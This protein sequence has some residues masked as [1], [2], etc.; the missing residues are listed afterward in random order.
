MLIEITALKGSRLSARHLVCLSSASFSAV[1]GDISYDPSSGPG[2]IEANT[3]SPG[4]P[5]ANSFQ[6]HRCRLHHPAGE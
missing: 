3:K 1:W 5:L 2:L 4:Y 6:S